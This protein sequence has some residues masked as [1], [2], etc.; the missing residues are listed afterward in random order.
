[1]VLEDTPAGVEA[2]R[3]AG[4][5]VIGVLTTYA[6]LDGCVAAVRD[7]AS[8]EAVTDDRQTAMRLAV[9]ETLR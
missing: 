6:T 1:V 2:G 8:I 3:S 5:R 9:R 7:L 4:A